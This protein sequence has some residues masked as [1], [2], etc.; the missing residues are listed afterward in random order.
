L[1]RDAIETLNAEAGA[2]TIEEL[3]SVGARL[4]T[5]DQALAAL[6]DSRSQSA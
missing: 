6:G 2:K 3:Q 1:V 5:T 4:V